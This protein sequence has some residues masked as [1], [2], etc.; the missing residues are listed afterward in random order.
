MKMH[1][2]N[3]KYIQ[4]T[5]A[6]QKK[7]RN[8]NYWTIKALVAIEGRP[9]LLFCPTCIVDCFFENFQRMWIFVKY[10]QAKVSGEFGM[11]QNFETFW[12]KLEIIIWILITFKMKKIIKKIKI[13]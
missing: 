13:L 11:S 1:A 5:C 12:N 6:R 7:V 8:L 10:E 9:L 2:E 3:T 4:S